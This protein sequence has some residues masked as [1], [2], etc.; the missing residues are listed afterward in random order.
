MERKEQKGSVK[1]EI[2]QKALRALPRRYRILSFGIA[3]DI[4][5]NPRNA[6]VIAHGSLGF[7]P[8][9]SWFCCETGEYLGEDT[10]SEHEWEVWTEESGD[11][12]PRVGWISTADELLTEMTRDMVKITVFMFRKSVQKRIQERASLP[13]HVP[14]WFEEQSEAK[15]FVYPG[16]ADIRDYLSYKYKH[17][18]F[19]G[20]RK[21]GYSYLPWAGLTDED[22]GNGAYERED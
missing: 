19:R 10:M 8:Q 21:E 11:E 18:V 14:A 20:Y 16:L 4:D 7:G 12:L 3:H 5:D 1:M 13:G 17:G 6:V 15:Q 22:L 9:V 2:S